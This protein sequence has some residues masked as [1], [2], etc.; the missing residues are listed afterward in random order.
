MTK[1]N[2]GLSVPC[3]WEQPGT[4][5]AARRRGGEPGWGDHQG[6]QGRA[7]AC[8][9]GAAPPHRQDEGEGGAVSVPVPPLSV[10][11]VPREQAIP[12]R[13]RITLTGRETTSGSSACRDSSRER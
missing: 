7:I 13:P 3:L 1:R 11:T 6:A 5:G 10:R 9:W 2:R 4:A 12:G 8:C